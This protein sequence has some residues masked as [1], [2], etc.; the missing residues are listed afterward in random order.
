LEDFVEGSYRGSAVKIKDLSST[1]KVAGQGLIRWHVKDSFGQVQMIEME[2]YHVPSASVHLLSMQCIYNKYK[3][4]TKGSQD[5]LKYIIHLQNNINLEAYYYITYA[6]IL[7]MVEEPEAFGLWNE[8][9]CFN[10]NLRDTWARSVL[11]EKNQ[12]LNLAQQEFLLYG[13]SAC[14]TT[15]W[16][17]S[18]I[19]MQAKEGKVGTK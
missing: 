14:G 2:G 5:H 8:C 9:F 1:N 15:T 16:P 6:S 19:S 17:P 11:D 10:M 3:S 18:I 7:S 13:I 4:S 12:N